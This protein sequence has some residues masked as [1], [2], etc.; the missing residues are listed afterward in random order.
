MTNSFKTKTGYD[1]EKLNAEIKRHLGEDAFPDKAALTALAQERAN[2]VLDII[3][4]QHVDPRRVKVGIEH[5]AQA[6]MGFVPMEFTLTVFDEP[7]A[8][9]PA[10]Q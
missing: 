7:K 8:D 5:E 2:N 4:K 10:E 6:S 9:N 1:F 3:L